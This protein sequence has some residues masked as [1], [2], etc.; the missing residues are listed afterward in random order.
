MEINLKGKPRWLQNLVDKVLG[1]LP[2]SLFQIVSYETK[3]GEAGIWEND[4]YYRE[5]LSQ[6]NKEKGE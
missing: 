3:E 4:D 6:V 5:I 2:L 1:I